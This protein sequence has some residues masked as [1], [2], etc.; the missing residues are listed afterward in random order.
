[1]DPFFTIHC[2]SVPT[3]TTTTTTA[4]GS[5]DVAVAIAEVVK[6][7][8]RASAEVL[9]IYHSP[10]AE[11]WQV[12][13]KADDSPLTAADLAAN[14]IICKGLSELAPNIPI[15]SEEVKQLPYE[16]RMGYKYFW[17]VDPVDGTK[18]FLKRTGRLPTRQR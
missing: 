7:V 12:T 4:A 8:S 3:T 5:T 15:I 10:S 14:R 6:L 16:E 13:S 9:R 11:A 17:L 1:M 18:E 2:P